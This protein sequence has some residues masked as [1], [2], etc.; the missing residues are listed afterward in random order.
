[1]VAVS[2]GLAEQIARIAGLRRSKVS[3]IYNP[4]PK[5]VRSGSDAEALW[6]RRPRRRILAMGALK[7]AKNFPLLL[8]A[9]AQIAVEQDAVLAIVGEGSSRDALQ[10]QADRLGLADRVLMPG[11]CATPGDWY[12]GADLFVLS[13]AYE[14]FGNVLVEAMHFG[15]P[16]VSTDC[17]MGPSEILDGGRFGTLVPPDDVDA[18][19]DAIRSALVGTPDPELARARA[20]HYSVERA[21]DAYARLLRL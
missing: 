2:C 1:V 13:S 4:V 14:G 11:F 12:E 16:V 7:E 8:D 20:R 18:L 6:P 10:S 21:V 3:V 17:P 19:A 15:L 5:P 9:F